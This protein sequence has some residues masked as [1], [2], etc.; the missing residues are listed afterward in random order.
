LP[1]KA[2]FEYSAIDGCIFKR[3]VLATPPTNP[4]FGC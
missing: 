1:I 2:V 4:G 3:D